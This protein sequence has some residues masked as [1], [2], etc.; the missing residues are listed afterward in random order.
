MDPGRTDGTDGD[1]VSNSP[2]RWGT[3]PLL[4]VDHQ[5]LDVLSRD[6]CEELLTQNDIGRIGFDDNGVTVILPVNYTFVAGSVLF[7]TAPGSKLD[8]AAGGGRASFEIDDWDTDIRSG[9]SVL[10]KGRAEAMTEA[11]LVTL[12]ERFDVEPWADKIPRE[13]WIRIEPDEITGRWIHRLG[14]PD[15]RG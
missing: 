1:D 3:V 8:L 7:R 11:W 12:A 10:V 13:H 2:A 4:G 14:D 6:E 15:D 9:W 5:G